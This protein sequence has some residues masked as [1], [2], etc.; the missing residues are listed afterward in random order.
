MKAVR[1]ESLARTLP[2]SERFD[3]VFC[4]PPW[5]LIDRALAALDDLH[6]FLASG[7]RVVL[8]HP[9]AFVPELPHL[10]ATDQRR[11]G[12]TGAT[13]FEPDSA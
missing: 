3:L 12:D 1:V 6:A 4:D 13:F 2:A 10:R 11:W 5:K 7:A 9:A 8:E